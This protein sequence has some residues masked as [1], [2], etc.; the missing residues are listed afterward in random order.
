MPSSPRPPKRKT[1]SQLKPFLTI[2]SISIASILF[3]HL[4]K[5][6]QWTGFGADE[7]ISEAVEQTPQGDV[8]RIV[9]TT[10]QGSGKTL[11]DVLSLV[12]VPAALAFLGWWLQQQQAIQ[13]DVNLRE[14]ALK[15]YIDSVADLL[16]EKNLVAI[17]IRAK[18]AEANPGKAEITNN[19]KE[20]FNAARDVIKARTLSILRRLGDDLERKAAAIRFLGEAEVIEKVGLDLEQ[21]DLRGIN[22]DEAKLNGINLAGANLTNASFLGADL[23]GANLMVASLVNVDFSSADLSCANF[24]AAFVRD[25]NFTASL[26]INVDL[27]DVSRLTE[28]QL[29]RSVICQ[30]KLPE[31]YNKLSSRDCDKL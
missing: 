19:E 15:E 2:V 31:E 25:A 7:A 21:I 30:A 11:W 22:L 27:R 18:E 23:R 3:F 13:A 8:V 29:E 14:E 4:G 17:A 5:R 24:R 28:E 10:T 16:I 1:L 26:L 6:F 20:L 12:G 9:T